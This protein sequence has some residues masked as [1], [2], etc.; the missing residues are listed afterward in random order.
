MKSRNPS[1]GSA[2]ASGSDPLVLVRSRAVVARNY[3][4]LTPE[5]IPAAP[6]PGWPDV[7][8]RIL[9][10]PAIGAR[11]SMILLD[12]PDGRGTSGQALP[13]D[14]QG[15]MFVV[16]GRASLEFAGA[17]HDLGP[18]GFAYM[19]PA[20][21]FSLRALGGTARVLWTRKRYEPLSDARPK[22]VVGDETRMPGETW[23]FGSGNPLLPDTAIPMQGAILKTLLPDE[24]IYDMAM[25]IFTFEPGR[26]LPI[27]ETHVMEHGLLF[28]QGQGMYLLGDVW[29]EV[30]EGDFIWMGPYAPQSFY[31]TGPVASRYLYYK[32]VHRD[33]EL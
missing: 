4:I 24:M 21:E 19:P 29:Y 14:V 3:A 13:V 5:G 25:N 26:G 18:G 16:E 15:F 33:I 1:A 8:A 7:D 27:T 23:A 31:A 9:G 11:F 17:K 12:V 22:A 2:G 28:L 20:T 6:I 32:N 30:R 10:A